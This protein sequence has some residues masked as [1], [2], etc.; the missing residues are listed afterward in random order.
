[1]S[2]TGWFVILTKRKVAARSYNNSSGKSLSN[3][4]EMNVKET[5]IMYYG[6]DY[7]NFHV[8]KSS[9]VFCE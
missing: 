1:M 5:S 6:S 9:K 7:S 4:F 8:S 3:S 2:Q